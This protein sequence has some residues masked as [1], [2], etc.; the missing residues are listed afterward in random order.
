MNPHAC[1]LSNPMTYMYFKDENKAVTY[2]P[3]ECVKGAGH[4]VIKSGKHTTKPRSII[5]HITNFL[6]KTIF[7]SSNLCQYRWGWY[8]YK[9]PVRYQRPTDEHCMFISKTI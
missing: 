9:L 3:R 7:M 6:N 1:T 4:S 5:T 8:V 2:I